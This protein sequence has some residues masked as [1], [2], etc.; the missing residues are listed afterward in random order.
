MD[1]VNLIPFGIIERYQKPRRLG[2]KEPHVRSTVIT[3][4]DVLYPV[5]GDV[6][7]KSSQLQSR[8][9]EIVSQPGKEIKISRGEFDQF[10]AFLDGISSVWKAFLDVATAVI[11]ERLETWHQGSRRGLFRL[12]VLMAIAIMEG[13]QRKSG[14][15]LK[16]KGLGGA[17]NKAFKEAS[18]GIMM[19]KPGSL[20]IAIKDFVSDDFL[21]DY[22]L[23]ANGPIT[24]TK[25]GKA[26]IIAGME[27]MRRIFD[28]LG[29]IGLLNSLK[30]E[31]LEYGKGINDRIFK[32]PVQL[33]DMNALVQSIAKLPAMIT[34]ISASPAFEGA[35]DVSV[36]AEIASWQD[37]LNRGI[38]DVFILG[39]L[40]AWPSYGN[41]LIREAE[42]V[43]DI[44][45]GTLYPKLED[46]HERG[47]ILPVTNVEKLAL[48]NKT[49]QK[50]QGPKKLFYEITPR[51]ALYLLA[52]VS[53]QL[54]DLNVFLKLSQE[55]VDTVVEPKPASKPKQA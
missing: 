30:Q 1:K 17:I 35:R 29:K 39:S 44:P 47:L 25:K 5:I 46:F 16:S 19:A 32:K 48:L 45:T 3:R 55:L 21:A 4:W 31:H 15:S 52:V 20:Y 40:L 6:L 2:M 10:G 41:A 49:A 23:A 33:V 50:T 18:N 37:N 38:L 7:A 27:A 54:A 34:A 43:L 53:L 12:L 11:S 28:L 42:S 51:G 9:Q 14:K 36:K 26:F 8:V 13:R 24:M 22:D